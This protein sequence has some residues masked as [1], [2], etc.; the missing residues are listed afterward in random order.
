MQLEQWLVLFDIH[1]LALWHH[2][3]LEGF[4]V[5]FWSQ[6]LL[7]LSRK[8]NGNATKE[9]SFF[10]MKIFCIYSHSWCGCRFL[11]YHF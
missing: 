7:F 8:V 4:C 11:L 3:V 1:Y 9:P 10:E 5:S 6:F 2:V